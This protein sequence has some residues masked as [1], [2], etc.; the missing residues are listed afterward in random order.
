MGYL[1]YLRETASDLLDKKVLAD[2][3]YG[4]LCLMLIISM[5]ISIPVVAVMR[6]V[7]TK[8]NMRK[9]YGHNELMGD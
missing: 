9:Q 5:P 2:M 6:M 3:V 7:V 4:L 8:R 1:G